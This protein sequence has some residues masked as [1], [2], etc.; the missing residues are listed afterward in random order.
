VKQLRR[1]NAATSTL[2]SR[3]TSIQPASVPTITSTHETEQDA[4]QPIGEGVRDEMGADL[5]HS[6]ICEAAYRLY[7]KRGYIDGYAVDDWLEAEAE[8][9]QRK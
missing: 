4:D 1:E 8:V 9:D 3:E 5:R 2:Q 7:E 6:M